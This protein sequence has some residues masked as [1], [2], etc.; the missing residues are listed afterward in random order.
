MPTRQLPERDHNFDTA[1]DT[2]QSLESELVNCAVLPDEERAAIIGAAV[3]GEGVLFEGVPG[4]GKT[5]AAKVLAVAMGGD[6]KRVQGTPDVMP[7]DIVGTQIYDPRDMEFKLRKG[8]IFTNVFLVDEANR[9][10]AKTQSALL[11][12]MQERQVTIGGDAYELP[13]PFVVLATQNPTEI[14]QGVNPLTKANRDRFAVGIQVPEQDA[15][16]MLAV[17]GV[18]DNEPS[19]VTDLDTIR[20][21]RK[22]VIPK[23][24]VTN[25]IKRTA[26]DLVVAVREYKDIDPESTVL[27][28]ARPFLN[29]MK[30][31]RYAALSDRRKTV[32]AQDIE[33]A[34][35]FVLPH[36]VGVKF[37]AMDKVDATDI[38]E[39][40]ISKRSA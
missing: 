28:G 40:A 27:G 1:F 22:L 16:T 8:P 17:E 25:D 37:E 5:R 12:A 11:E 18:M 3:L 35:R 26:T 38:V 20:D 34:A 9:M 29:I 23:I 10:T 31:A 4:T 14:G 24:A 6:F 32:E 30:I 15:D 13:N 36:R 19:Q 39:D 7:S 21:I 2:I 33:F